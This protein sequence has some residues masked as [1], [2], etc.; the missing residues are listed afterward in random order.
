MRVG[1]VTPEY[2][3]KCFGVG[4]YSKGLAEALADL[5]VIVD[6]ISTVPSGYL[7]KNIEVHNTNLSGANYI[8][9][10][11]ASH[12]IASCYY[13]R[14]L[15]RSLSL[16]HDNS[17]YSP[18]VCPLDVFTL[19][20]PTYPSLAMLKARKR[21][22]TPDRFDQRRLL[23]LLLLLERK[24]VSR[25][26]V[27]ICPNPKLAE[28]IGKAYGLKRERV[29]AIPCGINLNEFR[30]SKKKRDY[31][32]FSG[33]FHESKGI[34]ELLQAVRKLKTLRDFRLV[35]TGGDV[36]DPKNLLGEELSCLG[37]RDRVDVLGFVPRRQHL[38]LI[39]E[40]R[41][42]II[43]SRYE[44]F[45]MVALEA[46]ASKTPVL[47]SEGCGISEYL[48]C[49]KNAVIF[50]YGASSMA[51]AIDGFWKDSSLQR[52]LSSGGY[53][54]AKEFQWKLIAREVRGVYDS[55]V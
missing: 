21:L 29:K 36:S 34:Y 51:E 27:T 23:K 1:F 31:L 48:A 24:M 11:W 37:I 13:L 35:I 52:K 16:A 2:P 5:G 28:I 14:K 42:L 3:P 22:K 43:P 20:C 4:I 39:S 33:R 46:M 41:G 55:I 40:A 44:S 38:K 12:L 47:V 53:R 6:L 45:G 25:A 50:K 7:H 54:K 10:K 30:T 17:F 19:H 26:K 32:L 18:G 49:G 9:L 15:R 8:P